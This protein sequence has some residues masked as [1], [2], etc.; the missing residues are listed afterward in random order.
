MQ[1]FYY[2]LKDNPNYPNPMM[3]ENKQQVVQFLME[4]LADRSSIIKILDEKEMGISSDPPEAEIPKTP[5]STPPQTQVQVQEQVPEKQKEEEIPPKFF[6]E[7]GIDF[8]LENGRLYKKAWKELPMSEE[9]RVIRIK[10]GAIADSS[11]F[12]LERLEWVE[13]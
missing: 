13:I 2:F 12:S 6:S 9:F 1:R 4:D 11:Q 5:P 10:T 8:K 7:A 3:A